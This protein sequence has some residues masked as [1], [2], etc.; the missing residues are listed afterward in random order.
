M[1]F[2][3]TP[4]CASVSFIHMQSLD[5]AVARA[6]AAIARA[7]ALVRGAHPP[8]HTA[9]A[10]VFVAAA[11]DLFAALRTN[12]CMEKIIIDVYSHCNNKTTP[13]TLDGSHGCTRP[14]LAPF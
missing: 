6:E 9:A 2:V 11:D 12:A 1:Y 7:H 4:W 5:A 10:D 3:T 8:Q 13:N 14:V